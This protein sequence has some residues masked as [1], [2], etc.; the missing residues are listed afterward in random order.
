[1]VVMTDSPDYTMWV[2]EKG[3]STIRNE[4]VGVN[5][6]IGT[7]YK[8]QNSMEYVPFI[9]EDMMF[10]LNRCVFDTGTANFS[11]QSEKLSSKVALDKFRFVSTTLD[12]LSNSPVVL[13]YSFVSKPYNGTKETLYRSFFPYITY[14]MG[15]DDVYPVGSR[16]KE[17]LNQGDFTINIEMSSTDDAI[18]P[19]VSL[20]SLYLN[21]WE[22]FVDN[23]ELSASDITVIA[24]GSGYSN[25]NTITVTSTTGSGANIYVIVDG[26]NGNIVGANVVSSGTG[27]TDDFT[28]TINSASG[29]NGQIDINSEYD[30]SRGPC[31]AKY[32]T[33]PITLADGFDAGDLRVFLSGNKPGSTEI[34]VFYKVLASTD[35]TQFKDRPYQK[36]ECINPTTTASATDADFREYEYRPSATVN[37]VS[38]TST[39]GV[40]FDTF[41][42][43]AIK[44]VMTSTD[45]AIVPKVKDLRIIALPAE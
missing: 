45:P 8:S 18:S 11:V 23:G 33:K 27:Y 10:I 24:S 37:Q 21:A 20:E 6:Y 38:Y 15:N 32:I 35:D 41:K 29:T 16:R 3:A 36:M 44:I 43:F 5:P 1:M 7:L 4:F 34:S 25:A 39:S 14:S 12:T 13:N 42:T 28:F 9:N 22:N 17:L 26:P 30:S 19:V 40:T 2:A 31:E